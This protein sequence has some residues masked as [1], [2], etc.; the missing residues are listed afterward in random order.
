[1]SIEVSEVKSLPL[2]QIMGAPILALVQAEAQAAQATAEFIERVGFISSEDDPPENARDV[3][4]IGQLRMF[5]FHYQK[6]GA[7]GG[8]ETFQVQIPLLSLVPI[9][10]VQVKEAEFEFDVH[11]HDMYSQ[12]LGSIAHDEE[13]DEGDFLARQRVGLRAGFDKR[14]FSYP[15]KVKMKIE[16]AHVPS[17]MLAL[18][19]VMDQSI[20][21]HVM[22][23]TPASET[24]D[25][26]SS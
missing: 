5:T 20:S 17:G 21:S 9:P 22:P 7:S 16:E 24:V 2:F 10:S 3:D 8:M 13:S 15:M 1:M 4:H 12:D 19:K 11:I 6:P 14:D 25:P 23:P 26:T 18:F